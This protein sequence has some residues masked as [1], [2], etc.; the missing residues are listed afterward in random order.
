MVLDTSVLVSGLLGGSSVPVLKRWRQSEFTL[1]IS[2]EIYAEYE[3]VLN[4]PKFGLPTSLVSE[5][6]SFIREQA[7]W[8]EP[9]IQLNPVGSMATVRDPS[10]VK[11]LEAAISG[12]AGVIVSN[13]RDLLDLGKVRGISIVPPWEFAPGESKR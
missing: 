5:L 7:H 8:V 4:R 1:V 12:E 10:D 3:A 2:P 9:D 13:D 6:L 11:F